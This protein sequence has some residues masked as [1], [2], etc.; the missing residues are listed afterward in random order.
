[1][2]LLMTFV[3]SFLAQYILMSF[4]TIYKLENFTHTLSKLYLSLMM[5]FVMVL[6]ELSM[7]AWNSTNQ[8]LLLW[9]GA[10][11]ALCV[12]LYR[13]QFGV[14]DA[15][16]LREMIEHHS[17]ALFTTDNVLRHTKRG[18]VAALASRINADQSAEIE[19]MKAILT[20]LS[21]NM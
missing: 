8:R 10:G 17:M 20:N 6:Y 3:G 18:D 12:L 16:F 9:N 7:R 2:N 5:G 14:N 19:R 1:M 21:N 15:N 13:F 11:F 4:V